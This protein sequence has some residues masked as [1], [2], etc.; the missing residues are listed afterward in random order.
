MSG[1]LTLYR[2]LATLAEP[3]CRILLH[4]RARLGRED[5]ARIG[6]RLGKPSESRPEGC[7][8]WFHAASVGEA[9]AILPIVE[10]LVA[11]SP[12]LSV[13]VTTVTRTAAA[14]LEERL[15]AGALHQYV[16]ID[17]P[18]AVRRFL[19]HW[20]PNLAIWLESELWPTLLTETRGTGVPTVLLNGRMSQ[21]SFRRWSVVPKAAAALLGDFSLCLAADRHEARR[22]ALL[23]AHAKSVGNLKD[24][25]EPLPV[26]SKNLQALQVAIGSRPAWIAAST[27]AVEEKSIAA[28]HLRLAARHSRLLTIIAPRHPERASHLVQELEM[29]GLRVACRTV[30]GYP[31]DDLDIL[32]VDTLGE[33]GLFFRAAPIAFVGGSLVPHGGHNLLEPARLGC[34]VLHGPYM[35]NFLEQAEA[36]AAEK[37]ALMVETAADLAIEVDRLLDDRRKCEALAEAGQRL[38][39]ARAG[40]GAAI[41]AELDP[42][43]TSLAAAGRHVP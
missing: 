6:E 42:F 16:P 40:A 9:T 2:A 15:P 7:L 31:S 23:G 25:A 8:V 20:R 3:A 29:M 12:P 34:A 37:A 39:A 28:V 22:L 43:L 17:T 4:R 41:L 13:L 19:S 18:V 21:K 35:Q 38:A 11:S 14:I 27:H 33:L 30:R 32:L 1:A 24:A 10:A 26:R 36:F 5:A